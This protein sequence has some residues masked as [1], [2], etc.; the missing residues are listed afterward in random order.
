M[1]QLVDLLPRTW[2]H[3]IARSEVPPPP[4]RG[5]TRTSRS[6]RSDISFFQLESMPR[7]RSSS[8]LST[9]SVP[10]PTV[11]RLQ[12][13]F[14]SDPHPVFEFE[15][16]S[17]S[18]LS[19]LRKQPSYRSFQPPPCLFRIPTKQVFPLHYRPCNP[20]L[21][22]PCPKMFYSSALLPLTRS[23]IFGSV[24]LSRNFILNSLALE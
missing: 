5:S 19:F 9:S 22:N 3:H 1:V 7:P 2:R 11:T 8:G 24:E 6:R 12:R 4:A 18:F 20:C 17:A 21:C 15:L 14:P 16:I 23:K 13:S 10:Q